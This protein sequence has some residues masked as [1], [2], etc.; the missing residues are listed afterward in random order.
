MNKSIRNKKALK[1]VVVAIEPINP[2]SEPSPNFSVFTNLI[3][4]FQ[5]HQ[6]L[7]PVKIASIINQSMYMVPNAW[8]FDH[9]DR[10]AS[11]AKNQIKLA[12]K[13]KFNFQS[14]QVL[15]AKSASNSVLVEQLSAYLNKIRSSLLV[16][17]SSNR[18]GIPYYLLGSFAET[19]AFS[20]SKSVLVIKPQ[21]KNLTFSTKPQ[22]T[23]ALDT[24]TNYSSKQIKWIAEL[25]YLSKAHIN[26]ISVKPNTSNL[27]SS[28]YKPKKPKLAEKELKKFEQSLSKMGISTSLKLVK[29]K[30]SIAQTIVDFADKTKSW[31]IIT[32]SADRQLARKILLGS[33]AR[34]VLALT[35]RPFLSVRINQK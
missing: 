10:Y 22:L 2:I 25:A 1:K 18:H 9:E 7:P 4:K 19:A 6:L 26:L 21:A 31:A 15:K 20:A 12:C 11:E 16:V 35:K 24:T 13:N 23:V 17:L 28:L 5:K 32:I 30:E 14:I 3:K 8:Y 29:E 33:T 34:K 27:L